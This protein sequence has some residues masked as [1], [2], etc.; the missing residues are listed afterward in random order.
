MPAIDEKIKAQAELVDAQL[1]QLPELP[2]NNVQHVV[3]QCLGDFSDG[4]RRI[5][6]GASSCN[7]FLSEWT[8]LS[9]D[10]S[11]TIQKMKPLFVVSDRSDSV[12][13][14]VIN[15][16]DDTDDSSQM[17]SPRTHTPKRPMENPSTPQ[18]KRQ[19]LDPQRRSGGSVAPGFVRP[20][21]EESP[22]PVRRQNNGGKTTVFDSYQ[23]AG[24]NFMTIAEVRT[25]ISKHKRPGH[26][27]IVTDAAR[28]EICLMSLY[29][30]KGPL[31]TLMDV[32]F[33]MLR[34]AIMRVM[35]RTL[36]LYRQT[37]LFRISQSKINELLMQHRKDQQSILDN[38]YDLETYKLF[39]LNEPAFMKYQEEELKIL[40]ATRRDIRVRGYVKKQAILTKKTLTDASRAQLEKSVTDGELGPD[41]FRLEIETAA[42]VR[43]Y[44]KTAGYRFSDNLCQSILGHLLK[45]IHGQIR[46]FL[47]DHFDLNNG[48]SEFFIS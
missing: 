27:G 24:K 6:E 25:I 44:Y 12:M 28:E 2:N 26:P 4:V 46:H 42:Y 29:A 10:F 15:L 34:A 14:E 45:N 47:E 35:D 5:L 9:T 48:D 18:A 37:D 22:T 36:G 17:L 31:K 21:V 1:A 19:V 8:Q 41:P 32:T 20:K 16:D 13:Q 7:E 30:W 11:D 43:G 33:K 38:F 40:Q 3:R 23:N 39:T